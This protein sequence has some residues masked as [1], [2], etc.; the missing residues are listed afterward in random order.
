MLSIEKE[1]FTAGLKFGADSLAMGYFYTITPSRIPD[2]SATFNV[3]KINFKKRNLSMIRSLT[4]TDGKDQIYFVLIF[5]EGKIKD[6]Y[7]A[8]VA[9]IYRS[10][11]LAWS[12][13]YLLDS[14]P[15]ELIFVQETGE[16][17]IKLVNDLG[18][19]KIVVIDKSGRLIKM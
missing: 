12:F 3:D 2:V 9:K 16:L 18:E 8:S 14:K 19:T 6:K 13:N 17:S 4:K 15:T 11:G 5:S 7:T 1:H 10:D